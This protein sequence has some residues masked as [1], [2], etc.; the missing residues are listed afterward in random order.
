M[1]FTQANHPPC[2]LCN[3]DGSQRGWSDA[4][5]YGHSLKITS[6]AHKIMGSDVAALVCTNCGNIQFF[7]NPQDFHKEKEEA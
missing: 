6:E 5:A 3:A 7:V 2:P 4:T 1:V